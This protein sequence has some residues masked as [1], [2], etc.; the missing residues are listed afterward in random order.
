MDQKQATE[1]Q[2]DYIAGL[3]DKLGLTLEEAYHK[4]E[5]D[6]LTRLDACNLINALTE[7]LEQENV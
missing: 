6:E 1:K 7:P 4:N 5:Y 3:L 2:I